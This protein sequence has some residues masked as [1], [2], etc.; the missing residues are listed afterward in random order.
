MSTFDDTR[1]VCNRSNL[2]I[3]L[4]FP[5]QNQILRNPPPHTLPRNRVPNRHRLRPRLR[6][7]D[8]HPDFC[9]E[10]ARRQPSH[11]DDREAFLAP[12]QTVLHRGLIFVWDLE[13]EMVK[14]NDGKRGI[15]TERQ[16]AGTAARDDVR[17]S[18][19]AATPKVSES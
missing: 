18:G 17:V 10:I 6:I 5:P 1:S 7:L 13:Q 12:Q 16:E 14:R 8:S 3:I 4:G 15:A 2:I 19:E 11:T 9:D